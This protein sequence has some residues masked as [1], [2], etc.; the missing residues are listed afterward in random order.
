MDRPQDFELEAPAARDI[1]TRVAAQAPVVPVS[2]LVNAARTVLERQL[3]LTWISGEISNF[4]RA[5]S[6]HCYFNL[7][8][9]SA[10]VRCVFFRTKAQ[11]VRFA[12]KDGLEVELRAV[13]TIYEARGEFQLNVETMR[14]A[15]VGRLYERFAELKARLETA[16]WFAAE[17]KRPIPAHPK[18]VGV[19]T[20]LR[21]AALR[22]V[23]TTLRRR[24]PQLPVILYPAGVQGTGAAAELAAAIEQANA[25]AEV[26]VL[27]VCRGGGSIEDLWPFNEEVLARAVYRSRLPVVSGVGHETDFTICDFVADLR[28]PTPT[29]AAMMVSPDGEALRRALAAHWRRLRAEANRA[30]EVRVQ[31][32]DAAAPRLLHPA[33]R[34][35]QQQ[36]HLRDL[37]ERLARCEA[38]RLRVARER[39][40]RTGE[41]FAWRLRRPLAQCTA[42]VQLKE[43]FLRAGQARVLRLDERLAV[44]AQNLQHLDPTAVLARGYAIVVG[45]DGAVVTDA[46]DLTPGDDVELTL[47]R[48]RAGARVTGRR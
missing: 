30:L 19:V 28:A 5:A 39:L 25:R 4:T 45:E 17:R 12:L 35:A 31:R 23:L 32:L 29:A 38:H 44:L 41:A 6:G 7:K 33:A 40:T 43:G 47:A 14:Q 13:P 20:S 34:I 16:G 24:W 46:A 42:V 11:F 10:Q 18:A 8:D 1:P 3:G 26:D 22:D 37:G 27:I 2:V 9:A 15:G 21:A 36:R 48:G